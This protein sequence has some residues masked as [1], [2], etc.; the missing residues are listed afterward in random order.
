MA[1]PLTDVGI[2]GIFLLVYFLHRE[3]DLRVTRPF[4]Y[5]REKDLRSF[6]EKVCSKFY[7]KIIFNKLLKKSPL[8]LRPSSKPKKVLC[9]SQMT[10]YFV[11]FIPCHFLSLRQR[12]S[13]PPSAH[14]FY[15]LLGAFFNQF[16]SNLL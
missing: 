15:S 1:T 6:A 4:V 14:R 10:A 7:F 12:L 9:P 2:V 8:L 16:S 11:V 3:G 13:V 5:V